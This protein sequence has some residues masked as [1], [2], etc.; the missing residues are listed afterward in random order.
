[1][2]RMSKIE[3][4]KDSLQALLVKKTVQPY[5]FSKLISIVCN[6]KFNALETFLL[7]R[8]M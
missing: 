1:M 8:D 6:L 5:N 2:S 3:E 7:V 4:V